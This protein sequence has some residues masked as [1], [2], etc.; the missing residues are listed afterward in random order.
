MQ[1]LKSLIVSLVILFTPTGPLL[2]TTLALVI[3]DLITGLLAARKQNNPVT[4]LGLKRTVLKL[5]VYETTILL[6]SLTQ[7]Y[8]TG[9]AI[10]C[11]NIASSLIGLTELKSCVENL[12][13]VSGS[14]MLGSVLSALQTA[15]SSTQKD[16]NASSLQ[17]NQPSQLPDKEV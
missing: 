1:L 12:N 10:P 17:S 13:I 11:L 9:P 8:L 4:S 15:T 5:F 3:A 14:S 16:S 6:A 2:A 7:T